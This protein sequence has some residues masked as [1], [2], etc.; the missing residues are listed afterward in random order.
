MGV[1]VDIAT[2][3]SMKKTYAGNKPVGYIG[4][5]SKVWLV[6]CLKC[7]DRFRRQ[8]KTL[9][10]MRGQ[11]MCRQRM[12]KKPSKYS[13]Y[14]DSYKKLEAELG[15]WKRVK[16]VYGDRVCARWRESFYNFVMDMGRKPKGLLVCRKSARLIMCKQNCFWG[17]R[18]QAECS[19]T[20][21]VHWKHT[22]Y[23]PQEVPELATIPRSFIRELQA[24][25]PKYKSG[26]LILKAWKSR[27]IKE[28]MAKREQA[29]REES[30][31]DRLVAKFVR[32]FEQSSEQTS[33]DR[34]PSPQRV[35]QSSAG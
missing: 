33:G 5:K 13:K 12:V 35:F 11:C 4:G 1:D 2:R 29:A 17:T 19:T 18:S 7:G 25:S 34:L 31:M 9:L 26:S 3:I 21:Y 14:A 20:I 10:Q 32:C 24:R 16:R 6:E 8:E 27:V 15:E 30:R 23:W 28:T 22:L